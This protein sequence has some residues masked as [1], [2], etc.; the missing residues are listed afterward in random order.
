MTSKLN[1]RSVLAGSVVAAALPAGVIA[2]DR[3]FLIATCGKI[4][5]FHKEHIRLLC[6]EAAIEDNTP[7]HFAA[8]QAT[9]ALSREFVRYADELIAKPV[10]SWD[11]VVIRAELVRMGAAGMGVGRV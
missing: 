4:R 9:D 3:S 1:R 7:E 8:M 6:A 2:N 10:C 5:G 11:D